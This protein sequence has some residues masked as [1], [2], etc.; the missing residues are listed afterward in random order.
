[1]TKTGAAAGKIL[2]GKA[3]RGAGVISCIGGNRKTLGLG[4][5]AL[6]CGDVGND[7]LASASGNDR[8][9]GQTGRIN[10][11]AASA[12]AIPPWAAKKLSAAVAK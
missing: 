12:A 5:D 10:V 8:L 7:K 6:L 11:M 1:V 4:G 9:F 2:S 3:K